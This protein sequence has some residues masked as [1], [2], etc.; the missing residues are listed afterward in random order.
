MKR[1]TVDTVKGESDR[2]AYD[3]EGKE[4]TS[5]KVPVLKSSLQNHVE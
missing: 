4:E 1:L 5:R 2:R 3:D